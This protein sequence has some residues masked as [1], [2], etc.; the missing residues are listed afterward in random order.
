MV[1]GLGNPFQP[2][3]VALDMESQIM[4]GNSDPI[5]GFWTTSPGGVYFGYDGPP[6]PTLKAAGCNAVR[7]TLNSAAFLNVNMAAVTGTAAAPTWVSGSAVPG[8][9]KGVYKGRILALAQ[10]AMD[11]G[12]FVYW[13]LHWSSAAFNLGGTT[14]YMGT[15][16]Q[17]PGPD[18]D[19]AYPFWCAAA[20]AGP[21]DTNGNPTTGFPT[22]L[23]TNLPAV[24]P[25]SV[26]EVFN[27][28]YWNQLSGAAFT[29]A[30]GG[31]TVL[32]YQ[33]FM[34]Q[35]GWCS[36][37]DNQQDSNLVRGNLGIPAG[38]RTSGRFVQPWRS[39][40]YQLI[41]DGI[42]ANG[43]TNVCLYATAEFAH[44][45]CDIAQILPTD[46]LSPP[47]IGSTY[48]AYEV[49][50][51][52]YPDSDNGSC[53]ASSGGTAAALVLPGKVMSGA[54]G[55]PLAFPLHLS[56]TEYG[57]SNS[58]SGE[59][60]FSAH[61][62]SWLDSLPLGSN[63]AFSWI[64]DPTDA[65]GGATFAMDV[66][67]GS[68]INLNASQSGTTLTLNADASGFGVG[69]VLIS[70]GNG[71]NFTNTTYDR[72]WVKALLS[73]VAGKAGSTYQMSSAQTYAST[74]LTA[75][76]VVPTAI[77]GTDNFAWMQS[78][79]TMLGQAGANAVAG[80]FG[81]GAA[82]MKAITQVS[83]SFSTGSLQAGAPPS[84]AGSGGSS[85]NPRTRRMQ[86]QYRG[87]I[88]KAN[89]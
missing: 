78:K 44:H 65:Q 26:F 85:P 87:L 50:S 63:G 5:N 83:A 30:K 84:G 74:T 39:P 61:M 23:Q 69:T 35:G 33:Q 56:M 9:P 46:T 89:R 80:S 14:K 16:N 1:D 75:A 86:Q 2:R 38:V 64:W 10:A 70:N 13:D 19:L 41:S 55:S 66:T 32:T 82:I 79:A 53:D 3:G 24:I 27:E 36:I 12:M 31:G 15:W 29:T 52:G 22:W 51:T 54:S 21:N 28:P 42:R 81:V 11:Y 20:N 8:D 73:G 49:S 40:G 57:C 88:R 67:Y 34:L 62:H 47:Q 77:Q 68:T 43:F 60:G 7:V 37:Y 45:L 48:H 17:S 59:T 72:P 76:N 71:N 25:R 58:V 18:Y 6:W 4:G